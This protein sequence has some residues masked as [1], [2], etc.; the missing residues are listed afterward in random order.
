MMKRDKLEPQ[1]FGHGWNFWWGD[2]EPIWSSKS[3]TQN[4]H[5]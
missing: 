1:I 2:S 4:P 5:Y 3:G